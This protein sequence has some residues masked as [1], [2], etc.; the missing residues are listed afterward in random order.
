MAF[1]VLQ[2]WDGIGILFGFGR[3]GRLLD[4]GREPPVRGSALVGE[5]L[6]SVSTYMGG[7]Q[8]KAVLRDHA[9]GWGFL[10]PVTLCKMLG[11]VARLVSLVLMLRLSGWSSTLTNARVMA[12]DFS[13]VY[14][15]PPF[16]SPP[17][18]SPF[19]ACFL[20][21]SDSLPPALQPRPVPCP[22]C[23][24]LALPFTSAADAHYA[25]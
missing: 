1:S 6:L 13:I 8:G 2:S 12:D 20:F 3:L 9:G 15:S 18:F 5:T 24:L 25:A 17:P 16:F 23:R 21:P 14:L 4:L 19:F 22:R 10:T 11:Y 7:S